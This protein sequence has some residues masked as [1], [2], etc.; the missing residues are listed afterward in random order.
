V[1]A[2]RTARRSGALLLALVTVVALLAGDAL[3]IHAHDGRWGLVP[4]VAPGS[5]TFVGRDYQRGSRDQDL[6]PGLVPRGSTSGGG[7]IYTEAGAKDPSTVIWVGKGDRI[8][9]YALLGGP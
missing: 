7:T 3:W 9:E 8:W 4:S 6:P 1:V 2:S 5:L